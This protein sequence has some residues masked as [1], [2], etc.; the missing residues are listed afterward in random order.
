MALKHSSRAELVFLFFLMFVAAAPTLFAQFDLAGEWSPLYHEDEKERTTGVDVGDYLGLPINAAAR[1]RADTWTASLATMPE[2]QCMPHPSVYASRGPAIMRFALE[3]NPA[4]QDV[5]KITNFIQYMGEFREIFMDGRPHPSEYAAHTWQGFS[6]GQWEGNILTVKTTHL[7][8]GWILRNGVPTS[9]QV[10][11]TD[12]W[13]RHGDVLTQIAIVEDPVYLTEPLIRTTN[14]AWTPEQVI[15]PYPCDIAEEVANRPKGLV[16]HYLPGGNPTLTEFALATGVPQNAARGGV[17]TTYPEYGKP[18][19]RRPVAAPAPAAKPDD[20]QVQVLPV[21]GNIY[22]LASTSG[23]MTVQ[24]GPDDILV[25]DTLPAR[26]SAPMLEALR[27]VSDKPIRYIVNTDFHDN[28][29]GGNEN[30]S[31]SGKSRLGIGTGHNTVISIEGEGA[32][33]IAHDGVLRRLSA[34]K[35]VPFASLPTDTYVHDKKELFFNGEPI[36]IIHQPN[37]HSDSDSIVFFRHT[38]VISTGDIFV[39]T[40]YPLMDEKE[41]GSI[42]GEID[43]LNVIIDLAI[44]KNNQE[45]GTYIIPGQGRICDEADVVEYRDMITII[46]DRVQDMIDKH[47]TLPQ[48]QAARPTMDYDG[49]YGVS[50]SPA[51]FVSA[52]YRDL[53][54]KPEKRAPSGVIRGVAQ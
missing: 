20:G 51:I 1:Q 7:K 22:M 5:V 14:W 12:H 23:N 8:A 43:A 19:V 29:T 39:T 16:P 48:V 10:T 34:V 54:A 15:R 6:T 52:I 24:I 31:K 3:I 26:L 33:I 13:I 53:T 32:Q 46:R 17:E 37:A 25:A 27:R 9:D 18:G 41:G 44:P 38:D 30:A 35:G 21:Q 45:G 11:M 47:M 4:T 28:H 42:Q 2:H 36:Q 40:G 50:S 49:R